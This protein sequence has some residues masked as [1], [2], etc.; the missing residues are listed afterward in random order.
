M[1]ARAPRQPY[2]APRWVATDRPVPLGALAPADAL[3]VSGVYP[4]AIRVPF[5][6]PPDLFGWR[7]DG[8]RLKLGY[9]YNPSIGGRSTLNVAI[10]D[11]F[12]D[13]LPLATLDSESWVHTIHLPFFDGPASLGVGEATVRIPA[14]KLGGDDTLQLQYYFQ[15][16]KGKCEE[17]L[18]N[19]RGSVDAS[20]TLDFSVFPHF[21]YL[22]ELA[23]FADG[24]LP[25]TRLADLADTGVILP[26]HL[27]PNAVEAFLAIM[28]RIG[29]FTGY[30]AE[31]VRIGRAEDVGSMAD[32]NLIVI[33]SAGD[34]P[35]LAQW[36]AALPLSL[37]HDGARL[38]VPGPVERLRATW[39]GRDVQ[40]V[41]QHAGEVIAAAD[42]TLGAIMS[43]ESPLAGQ[44]AV[45]AFAAYDDARVAALANLFVEPGKSQFVRGD[46]VLLNGNQLS[47]YQVGS[48]YP[49]GHLPL[50]T[51]LRWRLS[52]QPLQ[53]VLISF[54]V[55]TLIAL[56]LY[57]ALRARAI[58]RKN[59]ER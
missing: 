3:E 42:K 52:R 23:L 34:Q 38:R 12:V 55:A 45:V 24:G 46:L 49:S 2:D 13:A 43:F 26:E 11:A 41:Q 39:E 48:Q 5:K 35:L 37:E 54:I 27:T 20:S 21:S 4:G 1:P 18:D 44:H 32:R 25:F 58:A 51:A 31:R 6:L 40:G 57:R 19:L 29:N 36:Q 53:L 17:V 14:Y 16:R 28:G 56:M 30:P 15:H 22:P 50:L 8:A 59:A 9:R 47:H 7:N 33:G 10:N